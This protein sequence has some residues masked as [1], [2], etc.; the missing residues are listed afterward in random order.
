MDYSIA[1]VQLVLRARFPNYL[2]MAD[3]LYWL[4]FFIAGY[5]IYTDTRVIDAIKRMEVPALII[6]LVGIT[7]MFVL[8]SIGLLRPWEDHPGYYAGYL[9]YQILRSI[10]TWAW[11]IYFLSLGIRCFNFSN[12]TLRAANEAVLPFYIPH[13]TVILLIGFVV[14]SWPLSIPLKFLIIMPT[15]FIVTIAIYLF[16]KQFNFTRFLFGM[17]LKKLE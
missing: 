15:S 3:L 16:V 5:L 4:I 10:H 13:Q 8:F 2:D 17:R 6:G 11:I 9:I 12:S 1:L 7:I 14:V